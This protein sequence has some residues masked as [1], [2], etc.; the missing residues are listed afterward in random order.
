[1]NSSISNFSDNLKDFENFVHSFYGKG[2]VEDIGASREQIHKATLKVYE[3]SLESGES[4]FGG[5]FS[6]DLILIK[7]IL[8]NDFNLGT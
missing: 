6:S 2:G 8:I 1:M 5:L 7:F 3:Y 4:D